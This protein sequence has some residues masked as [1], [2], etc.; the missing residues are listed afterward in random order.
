MIGEQI[1]MSWIFLAI[2]IVIK[3]T[4]LLLG[5]IALD[6]FCNHRSAAFRHRIWAFAF[7][8]IALLPLASFTVPELRL[9]ILPKSSLERFWNKGLSW[10]EQDE[11]TLNTNNQAVREEGIQAS[12]EAG[13]TGKTVLAQGGPTDRPHS[14]SLHSVPN[15]EVAFSAPPSPAPSDDIT[16]SRFGLVHWIG[17]AWLFGVGL[18]ILPLGIG[19]GRTISL[20]NS[21]QSI[22][23]HEAARL[24]ADLCRKLNVHRV[25]RFLENHGS[26]VPM[27]WGVFRPVVMV[28]IDW[29]QWTP[30]RIRLVVLH[31]LAHVARLDV[32]YQT[33]ARIVCAVFWFHPLSWYALKRLR[34][35]RELACDDCVVMAGELPSHYARQLVSIAKEYRASVYP[36]AVAMAQRTGLENRI[37]SMLDQAR[38]H[39]PLTKRVALSMVCVATI[40]VLTLA[41]IRLGTSASTTGDNDGAK[42]QKE[43]G[44]ATDGTKTLKL[45]GVV[46]GPGGENIAQ[47]LIRV[48]RVFQSNTTWQNQFE[49]VAQGRA[50]HVGF[51]E[52]EVPANSSRFA[53]SVHFEEQSLRVHASKDGYGSDEVVVEEASTLAVLQLV[54]D[55][56][57]I[58]GRIVDLEGKPV[59]GVKVRVKKIDKP[60]APINEW[61]EQAKNNPPVVANDGMAMLADSNASDRPKIAFY[62]SNQS[63]LALD[64]REAPE[65]TT[66]A[67][68]SFTLRGVGD[69]RQATLQ[70]E[71]PR[72]A[73]AWVHCVA[74][75]MEP[76]NMPAMDPRYRVGKTFG[77]RFEYSCEP[78]QWVQGIVRD[79]G[80]GDPIP[81]VTVS[82]SQF[83]DNL[84]QVE[85]FLQTV[86]DTQGRYVLKGIPKAPNQSRGI[87]LRF[88][89]QDDQPYFRLDLSVPKSATLEPIDFHVD[90]TRGV[91][92]EGQVKDAKTKQPLRAMVAYYPSRSN[93]NAKDHE[94]WD[95]GVMTMGYDD[96]HP[97]DATGHFR[98]PGMVGTGVVRVVVEKDSEY[99]IVPSKAGDVVMQDLNQKYF[100]LAMPGNAMVPIDFAK[101]TKPKPIEVEVTPLPSRS[102]HV[103]DGDGNDVTEYRMAG[104]FPRARPTVSGRG[105]QYWERKP[106]DSA[107]TKVLPGNAMERKRPIMFWEP[108]RRLGAVIPLASVGEDDRQ[109]FRVTLQPCATLKGKIV[110]KNETAVG[111]LVHVGVG[112]HQVHSISRISGSMSSTAYPEFGFLEAKPL[113]KEGMFELSVPPGDNY[114]MVLSGDY[115]VVLFQDRTLEPGQTIDLGTIDVSVD[116]TK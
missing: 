91:W 67:D 43:T 48:V 100:H 58:E 104:R 90:M 36:P 11:N 40:A 8:S 83:G 80:T 30:D 10:A 17:F 95:E 38:S 45:S 29:R 49:I 57:A 16:T 4:L 64:E 46:V 19:I 70:L 87:R 98:I 72:I 103:V 55:T 107:V 54:S 111:G 68:G 79:R 15:G 89:P 71:S 44:P 94:A 33:L 93:G 77:R 22:H 62:P 5:V 65:T 108:K 52:L 47:A 2:D 56:K 116:R 82:L 42:S 106:L 27:T 9:T 61:L 32:V 96:M 37:R 34:T 6:R 41:P 13:W 50:N 105:M 84:L 24:F 25:V 23:D 99:E 113:S 88:L 101:D 69:G 1:D 97:T 39:S 75:D 63:I 73:T 86:T 102:F 12:T 59:A 114:A 14:K 7:V 18:A 3:M 78:T 109:P 85:G 115:N 81:G 76:V 92:I 74:Y 26:V 110:G 28:P 53:N 35:E 66:D 112:L 60:S 20:K 31:E 21:S 51:F